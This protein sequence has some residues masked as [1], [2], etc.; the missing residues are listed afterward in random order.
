MTQVT[1]DPLNTVMGTVPDTVAL[2]AGAVIATTDDVGVAVGIAVTVAVD[3]GVGVAEG[4]GEPLPVRPYTS[5]S[6]CVPR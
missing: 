4:V 5:S 3:P 6:V 2:L 1:P